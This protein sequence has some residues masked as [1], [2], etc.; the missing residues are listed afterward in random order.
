MEKYILG[1]IGFIA[2]GMAWVVV[3]NLWRKVFADSISED[4]VLAAR[5]N[6]DNCGCLGGVCKE[7][8]KS[9]IEDKTI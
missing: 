5:G 4:D 2:L 6:C 1:I 7:K 8:P 3:Q 9:I